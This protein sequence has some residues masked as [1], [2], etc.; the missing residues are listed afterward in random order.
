MR[1]PAANWRAFVVVVGWARW[2]WITTG[3]TKIFFERCSILVCCRW[4]CCCYW[5]LLAVRSSRPIILFI[6]IWVITLNSNQEPINEQTKR[7]RVRER[8]RTTAD[9][10]EFCRCCWIKKQ[11]GF[12][13]WKEIGCNRRIQSIFHA[14]I[15]NNRCR[16]DVFL[17]V[18]SVFEC[19][20]GCCCC[21]C[22]VCTHP[23]PVNFV[24]LSQLFHAC[25]GFQQLQLFLFL[26]SLAPKYK[27][28]TRAQKERKTK[29][30]ACCSDSERM[31]CLFRWLIVSIVQFIYG[32]FFQF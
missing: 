11:I 22:V 7:A 29:K 19:L 6:F 27:T 17:S 9:L 16:C 14:C 15:H 32:W 23:V 1:V 2:H 12:E 28:T 10:I 3:N 4:S 30:I 24:F 20:R 25:V 5:L 18:I 21:C 13:L 26:F 31:N 8:E